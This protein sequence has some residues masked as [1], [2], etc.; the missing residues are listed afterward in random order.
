MTGGGGGDLLIGDGA[1]NVLRGGDG[2]DTIGGGIGADYLDGGGG[3]D[4]AD[5]GAGGSTAVVANLATGRY[6]GGGAEG[7]RLLNFEG[8]IGSVF[9][10]VLTGDGDANR[11]LGLAGNDALNGGAGADTLVG[12]TGGDALGGGDAADNLSGGDGDDRLDGAADADSLA[13][14]DGRDMLDG[15]AGGDTI[16]GGGGDD[17]Y[18]VDDLGDVL[19]EGASEG[20][21]TVSASFSY[22]L[23]DNLENLVLI[24]PN[25]LVGVGNALANDISGNEE[26]NVLDGGG[27]ADVLRGGLGDDDLDGGDGGDQLEAGGGADTLDGGTGA[28][29]ME[30]G[31]GDDIYYVDDS[32]DVVFE[33]DEFG[34][35]DEIVTSANFNTTLQPLGDV[36]RITLAGDDDLR[37]AVRFFKGEVIGNAGDNFFSSFGGG[38]LTGGDGAD[39]FYYPGAV[40]EFGFEDFITDFT[41]GEDKIQLFGERF[42]LPPGELDPD[43]FQVGGFEPEGSARLIYRPENGAL[44]GVARN[45]ETKVITVLTG[46]PDLSVD[47]FIII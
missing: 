13:G 28:D 31:L 32:G 26:N 1:F 45:G 21:D 27:G 14:G 34:S 42:R 9:S 20:V 23:A 5:L 30:G 37:I 35:F 25:A 15:G 7:D 10:D 44:I 47:D 19:V 43:F 8:L 12:G 22:T 46:A 40:D 18:A 24:G 17:R 36:E 41:L 11:L 38:T 4:V 29:V 33:E 3:F 2:D 6:L 39:T 16:A